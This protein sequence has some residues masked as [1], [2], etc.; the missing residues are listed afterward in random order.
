MKCTGQEF[1]AFENDATYWHPGNAERESTYMDDVVL[2]ING[3]E[4]EDFD[5]QQFKDTDIIKIVAGGV[6]Y[7]T[8]GPEDQALDSYFRRWK[9]E[10]TS[11]TFIVECDKSK[12]DDVV[13][14]IKAA[15]GR[16]SK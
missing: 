16:V 8:K 2:E 13:A 10:Q 14:A 15:G 1:K 4:V 5:A 6:L 7:C 9:K 12:Y 3:E 11:M